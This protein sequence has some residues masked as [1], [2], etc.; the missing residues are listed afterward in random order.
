MTSRHDSRG[1]LAIDDM[2]TALASSAPE[3]VSQTSGPPPVPAPPNILSTVSDDTLMPTDAP[4]SEAEAPVASPPALPRKAAGPR[5]RVAAN[6]DAPSIGGLIHALQSRPSRKP[7]TYAA[8]ASGVW[9]LLTVVLGGAMLGG[10]LAKAASWLEVLARPTALILA[11][12]L[13]IPIALFWL[14]ANLVMRTQE[15]K[16][17]SSAMTEV[18][19]RLAEPDR[20]AEQ[21]IASLGQ[22]IRRQVSYMNNAVSHALGRANELEALVHN[23]VA[24][25][26]RAYTDNEAR[27]QRL[28]KELSTERHALLSTG[29]NV[30]E[31][32]R[33]LGTE[34]PS[35][36]D[37]LG[38]QQIRLARFI[39]GAGQNLVALESTLA[40]ATDRIEGSLGARVTTLTDA[41][42]KHQ[43]WIDTEIGQK[44]A[45]LQTMLDDHSGKVQTALADRTGQLQ[46]VFSEFTEA[47]NHALG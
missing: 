16:S 28:I 25:L 45:T 38:E 8:A 41:L 2:A 40:S 14:L 31:T 43:G 19:V 7:L 12:T 22:S 23:E 46:S 20:M 10:E 44:T 3:P 37:R 36:I 29:D 47:L 26:E 21:Q 4:T 39:E 27:I 34:I 33:N 13:L 5:T 11:A 17:M 15:L 42:E 1:N 32:L 6:D 35:M 18:A 30:S 9:A 24:A